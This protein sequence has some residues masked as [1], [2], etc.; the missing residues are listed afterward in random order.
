MN[1]RVIPR[2]A[3]EG[4]IRLMRLPLDGAI[5]L[6]PGN[7][8]GPSAAAT[9]AVDRADATARAVASAIL[10]DPVLR[11][12]A[13]RRRAAADERGRALRLR[14]QAERR[15]R[16]ADE[17]LDE[18]HEQSERQRQEARE[19]ADGRRRR[20]ERGRE[21]KKRGAVRTEAGRRATTRRAAARK[22]EAVEGRARKERLEALETKSGALREKE[23]ALTASDEARRLEQAAGRAKA[24]RKRR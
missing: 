21:E 10:G 3:V 20:A 17:H 22:A 12:D 16:E 9:L 2:T 11:E 1:L 24:A 15:T 7:G 13:L 23:E 4:Y 14:T 5:A 18:R 6:L 19:R 8:T